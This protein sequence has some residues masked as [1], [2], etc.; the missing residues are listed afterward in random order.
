MSL[1]D[2]L[3]SVLDSFTPYRLK[4]VLEEEEVPQDKSKAKQQ[5]H[6]RLPSVPLIAVAT[7]WLP[8]CS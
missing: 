2:D 3:N 1:L 4:G 8:S 5:S 6:W 7:F